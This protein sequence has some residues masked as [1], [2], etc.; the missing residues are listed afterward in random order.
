MRMENGRQANNA[1]FT[2]LDAIVDRDDLWMLSND[3]DVLLHFD[4]STLKLLDYHLI[5]GKK[6]MKYAHVRLRK[7][8]DI[9]YIV[10]YMESN[11]F[12][13][14]CVSGKIGSIYIPYEDDE[15]EVKN[16]FNIVTTWKSQLVLIGYGI[17]GCFYY[18]MTVGSFTKDIGYLKELKKLRSDFSEMPFS[19]C[20][21]QEKNKLYLPVYCK[22]II[23]EI[24]LE[25]HENTIYELRHEKEIRLR[26]IDVYEQDG[27]EK[28]LLTTVDDEMLIWSR[29][30]GVEKRKELGLLCGKEKI[31]MRAFHVNEKNYYIAACERKVFVESESEIKELKFEYERRGG[32]GEG[33]TQFEAVFR[34]GMD[35][36]FQARSNGQLFKIDTTTDRIFR[37]DFEVMPEVRDEIAKQVYSSRTMIDVMNENGWFGLDDFLKSYVCRKGG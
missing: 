31:Y 19:D 37:M 14:D 18:D 13:Y 7:C 4:F 30:S 24:D 8:G 22:N 35:I 3:A 29:M 1:M 28:F 2:A 5:P 10:P 21:C 32:V 33:G 25:K 36:Y 6:L 23:L 9:I 15:A 11:L 26:T 27:N 34:S 17:K 16:K 12:F 20:Y